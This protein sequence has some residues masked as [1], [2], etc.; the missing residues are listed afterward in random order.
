[1][2]DVEVPIVGHLVLT[3]AMSKT[4]T[5]S[6][7]TLEDDSEINLGKQ[8][9]LQPPRSRM[10]PTMAQVKARGGAVTVEAVGKDV[11]I[12]RFSNWRGGEHLECDPAMGPISLQ[13]MDA[14]ELCHGGDVFAV[15]F[16]RS[17]GP[18]AKQFEEIQERVELAERQNREFAAQILEKQQAEALA[19]SQKQAK[20][21][22]RD[23]DS[24][25][26]KPK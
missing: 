8:T 5:D 15:Q 25:E 26:F 4:P 18:T 16:V 22:A 12:R 6:V 17:A 24:D 23:F 2:D 20:K 19:S 1:M 11:F 10:S 7:I 3:W 14:I 21:R 13:H 9:L